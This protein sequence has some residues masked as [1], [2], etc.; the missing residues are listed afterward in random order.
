MISR[1][2]LAAVILCAGGTANAQEAYDS[3][4]IVLDGSGSMDGTMGNGQ[5]KMAAAKNALKAVLANAGESTHIGILAFGSVGPGRWIYPLSRIDDRQRLNAAINRL[6]AAG[7][8]PLGDCIKQGADALLD[9]RQ[10]KFG[11]GSST[12]LVITDGEANDPWFVDEYAPEVVA[13][14]IRLDVIGVAMK[15]DHT[16]ARTAHSYRRANDPK[17]LERAVSNVIAEVTAQSSD[18][19]PGEGAF[20]LA[21]AFDSEM[22]LQVI[23]ALANSGNHP[24]GEEPPAPV[25]EAD[26]DSGDTEFTGFEPNDTGDDSGGGWNYTYVFLFFAFIVFTIIRSASK[27]KA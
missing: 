13:R 27:S 1:L 20:E 11:Y 3:I 21:A 10:T 26:T 16:L 25:G 14:G 17:A 23:G 24:I 22:A 2:S 8:T 9:D 4:V 19:A 12:L 7:G 15:K 6:D 5:T 18:A